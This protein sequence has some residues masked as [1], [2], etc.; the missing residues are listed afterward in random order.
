ML[1]SI[2]TTHAPATDLGYLLNKHPDRLQSVDLAV[3]QA[4]VFYPEASNNLC[5]ACL[6]LDINPIELV[7]TRGQMAF[8]QEHY[9]NDRP[10]TS[11][12]FLSTAMVK[13][14]GS[15]MNG[16]SKGRPELVDTPLPVRATVY[17][18]KA[19]CDVPF[20][21]K[22]FEPLG[23]AIN[24][25]TLPLDERFPSWGNSKS[26]NLVVEKTTTVKELLSQLYVFILALDNDRHY[27]ISK[28][29][30][31]VLVRRGER[32]LEHHPEKEWIT[33]RFL[34]NLRTFTS[35]ALLRLAGEEALPEEGQPKS[36]AWASLHEQ[37]LQKAYELIK[38]SGASSVLD[39]G[40]GEGKLMKKL[41]KDAQFKRIAGMDVS[42]AELQKAKEN[43]F[44]DT[45]SPLMRERISLFQGSITYKDDRMKN[46]DAAA[47]VEVIEHLDEERLPAMEKV[48]FG[49]AKPLC[50]I[51]S[52]PNAEYN[53]LYERLNAEAFRHEDHRFEWTRQQFQAWC[54]KVCS[55]FDYEV[56]IYPVG[57]EAEGTGAPSQ[58]AVFK[59]NKK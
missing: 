1:L 4:H 30:I 23:Y 3:G 40:C 54:L 17:S 10:Y 34:K 29:D 50:V 14:F 37:R 16:T 41:I 11:N 39:L 20:I 36:K 21:Y 52:T 19:D 53:T 32:W 43:L 56:R 27:W 9:V 47:L 55:E 24:V 59:I 12:S 18:L 44:L 51:V 13:A 49:N 33:K 58:I 45:A 35:Q 25:E 48:I 28:T 6:L 5:T 31:D 8:L 26:I 7:R 38:Q 2:T 46:F 22:L 57:E 15:A 42:F